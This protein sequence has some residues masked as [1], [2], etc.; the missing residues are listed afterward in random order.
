MRYADTNQPAHARI[1]QYLMPRF[2]DSEGSDQTAQMCSLIWAFAVSALAKA[3][4][5]RTRY[6]DMIER[7]IISVSGS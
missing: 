6:Q 2:A 5:C 7:N 1:L 4:F 3:R